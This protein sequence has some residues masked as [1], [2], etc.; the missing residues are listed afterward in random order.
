M[1]YLLLFLLISSQAFAQQQVESKN[2]K[3]TIPKDLNRISNE[4]GKAPDT[5]AQHN[6]LALAR[7][8]GLK[9][10][11]YFGNGVVKFFQ[12]TDTAF[13]I[14]PDYLENSKRM[15]DEMATIQGTKIAGYSS[16]IKF[17]N[18]NSTLI[19]KNEIEGYIR[20]GIYAVNQQHNK[21]I[22]ATFVTLKK[23]HYR[24]R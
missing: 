11:R 4:M 15:F 19:V 2:V 5:Q 9:G 10:Q 22:T 16:A 8:N 14:R 13:S 24:S 20:Y 12:Y 3:L 1:K 6:M 21:I 17:N 18:N 7:V 23:R